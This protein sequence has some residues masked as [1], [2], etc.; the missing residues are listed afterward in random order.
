MAETLTRG[1]ITDEQIEEIY[2]CTWWLR[3]DVTYRALGGRYVP[4]LSKEEAGEA[5]RILR[6]AYEREHPACKNPSCLNSWTVCGHCLECGVW[7]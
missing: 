4:G 6:P 2:T 1:T 7:A 3:Y 5:L